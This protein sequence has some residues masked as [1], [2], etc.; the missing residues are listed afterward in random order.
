MTT[1]SKRLP[2]SEQEAFRLLDEWTRQQ[3]LDID[4]DNLKQQAMNVEQE[5]IEKAFHTGLLLEDTIPDLMK[6]AKADDIP[7]KMVPKT[8]ERQVVDALSSMGFSFKTLPKGK[9]AV[10]G[11]ALAMISLIVATSKTEGDDD[12]HNDIEGLP[13][14]KLILVNEDGIVLRLPPNPF[15]TGPTPLLGNIILM[16]DADLT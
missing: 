2:A 3:G 14:G 5:H 13:E 4:I 16:E 7:I 6:K 10:A 1:T 8:G 11:A 9:L 12:A 15:I